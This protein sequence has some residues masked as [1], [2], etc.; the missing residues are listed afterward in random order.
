MLFK[1]VPCLLFLALPF[2]LVAA[3]ILAAPDWQRS[4]SGMISEE[5]LTE[6][7]GMAVSRVDPDRLWVLN[8]GGDTATLYAVSTQGDLLGTLQIKGA[9]NSDWEDMASFSL[10]NKN[11]LLIGDMGDNAGKRK[12]CRFYVVE[13]PATLAASI[14]VKPLA[15]IP[16]SYSDGS[17]DVESIAV[18]VAAQKILLL[19][20]REKVPAF[21]ELPLVLKTALAPLLA[22]KVVTMESLPQPTQKDRESNPFMGPYLSQITAMDLSAD[23]RNLAVLTYQDVFIYHRD[24]GEMWAAALLRVPQTLPRHFLIQA[25]AICFSQDGRSI[26]A[27]SERKVSSPL[28]RYDLKN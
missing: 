23:G 25:E 10:N 8:D 13:E 12:D 18:D 4:P 2:Y 6:V 11:Y 3:E 7:S 19:S 28:I 17:R 24:R 27:T 15:I 16:F 20:K 14:T 1:F 5:R 9:E 22:K 21:Y 26:F